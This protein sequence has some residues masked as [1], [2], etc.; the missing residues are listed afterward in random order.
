[1]IVEVEFG[2]GVDVVGVVYCCRLING[3]GVMSMLWCVVKG[4]LCSGG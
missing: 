3:K 2:Y 4:F 1:M